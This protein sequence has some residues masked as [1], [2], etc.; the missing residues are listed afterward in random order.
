MIF[1]LKVHPGR[2]YKTHFLSSKIYRVHFLLHRSDKRRKTPSPPTPKTVIIFYNTK[3]E[4][5]VEFPGKQSESHLQ[6]TYSQHV[7]PKIS[8]KPV[9]RRTSFGPGSYQVR[10]KFALLEANKERT[11]SE[12][13]IRK[14]YTNHRS[15]S[16]ALPAKPTAGRHATHPPLRHEAEAIDACR[17]KKLL[18]H[19]ASIRLFHWNTTE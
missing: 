10:S 9:F 7:T 13:G 5:N 19:G 16:N 14:I 18:K 12:A 2:K 6:D 8:L 15:E 3:S 1:A 4:E 17:E 11:W